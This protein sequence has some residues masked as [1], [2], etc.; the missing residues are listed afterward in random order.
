MNVIF[1]KTLATIHRPHIF[2]PLSPH[3]IH[4]LLPPPPPDVGSFWNLN[5]K[6]KLFSPILVFH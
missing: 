2:H 5:H 3:V 4:L 1:G 6:L